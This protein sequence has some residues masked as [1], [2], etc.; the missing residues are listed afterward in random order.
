VQNYSLKVSV[1]QKDDEISQLKYQISNL[2]DSRPTQLSQDNERNA[3]LEAEHNSK[4]EIESNFKSEIQTE[5]TKLTEAV[6]FIRELKSKLSDKES[7]LRQTALSHQSEIEQ[8]K[9]EQQLADA[10]S[11]SE[12]MIAK[13]KMITET[14][15]LKHDFECRIHSLHMFDDD[16]FMRLTE[17]LKK[18]LDTSRKRDGITR[19]LIGA[20]TETTEEALTKF[21]I[22]K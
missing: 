15:Q 14:D 13:N 3:K 17:S 7:V 5:N 10:K 11:R 9:R 2:N 1:S 16:G 21:V 18:E 4:L 20:G 19:S 8:L 22:K 6:K 12:L